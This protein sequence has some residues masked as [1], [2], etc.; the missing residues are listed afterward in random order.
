MQSSGKSGTFTRIHSR[1]QQ[2]ALFLKKEKKKEKKLSAHLLCW[3]LLFPAE[4]VR[5][6]AVLT[7]GPQ[8]QVLPRER[9]KKK[10]EVVGILTPTL[11]GEK[12]L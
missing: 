4:R 5:G 10:K 7:A 2:A 6:R 12:T 1:G 3:I 8:A 11:L 9:Q